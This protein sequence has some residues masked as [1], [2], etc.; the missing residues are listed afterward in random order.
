VT[1]AI[2]AGYSMFDT[3]TFYDNFEP[4][5]AALKGRKREDFYLISKVWHDKLEPDDLRQDLEETL[6][7][8]KIK[9]LDAYLIH[10]PNSQVP[11]EKTLREMET[12]RLL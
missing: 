5:A 4:I 11:I 7:A 2:E 9:Y 10:W 12:S 6:A 1:C 3:A 8:L